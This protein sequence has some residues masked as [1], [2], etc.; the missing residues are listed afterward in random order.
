MKQIILINP[1]NVTD[2]EAEGY[3]VREASRA[4]VF[5]DNKLVALLH[6]TKYDYYKLPGGGI[7]KGESPEVAVKRECL[8]EIGCEIEILED[9]GTVLE[10]RKKYM[11]RQRSYCYIAKLV[12][13]KGT[14]NLMDDEVEE[15]FQTVWLTLD[16]ALEKVSGSSI[17]VYEAQYMVARDKAFLEAAVK[18]SGNLK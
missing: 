4:I 9:L 8:E 7:E 18:N 6:A 1:E 11:L 13:K 17:K 12:G 15:G 14:P 5:D 10:Y 2:Q 16:E 3:K